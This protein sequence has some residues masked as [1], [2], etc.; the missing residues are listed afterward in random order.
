MSD[1][2][3]A[4]RVGV[5]PATIRTRIHR[6][7]QRLREVLGGLRALFPPLLGSAKTSLALAPVLA[8]AVIVAVEPQAPALQTASPALVTAKP[9]RQPSRHLSIMAKEELSEPA[10][11]AASPRLRP[12]PASRPAAAVLGSAATP[13]QVMAAAPQIVGV[14]EEP[15]FELIQATPPPARHRCLIE[16]PHDFED[17]VRKMIEDA[18]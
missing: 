10:P 14:I 3:A 13:A 2:A 17:S 9:E 15:G 4:A 8:A 6:S 1:E 16:A 7:L 12:R 18:L 5:A 11:A